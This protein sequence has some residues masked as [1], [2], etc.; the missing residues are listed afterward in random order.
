LWSLGKLFVCTSAMRLSRY[1]C[2]WLVCAAF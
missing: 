2:S 1:L